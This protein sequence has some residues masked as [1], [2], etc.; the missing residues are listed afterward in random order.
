[1]YSLWDSEIE[2]NV[3]TCRNIETKEGCTNSAVEFLTEDWDDNVRDYLNQDLP[4]D[5]K[6]DKLK[7]YNLHVYEHTQP[8]EEFD[9]P[10]NLDA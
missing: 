5:E 9:A 1:M 10:A 7:G 4:L 6:I 8:V 2:R 3:G